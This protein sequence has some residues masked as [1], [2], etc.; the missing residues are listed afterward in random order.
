MKRILA[1]P[2]AVTEALRAAP[3]AIELVCLADSLRSLTTKGIEDLARRFRVDCEV[4]PKESLDALAGKLPHQGVIAIT[5]EYSYVDLHTLLE[6]AETHA[7]PQLVVLDQI[8]DP[9]NLGAIL[10]CAH[11]FGASGVILPKD[12]AAKITAAAVRTSAGA[13]ELIKVC[14]ITNLART[15]DE[16]KEAGY[17][18]YGADAGAT[19][20]LSAMGWSGRTALVMGSEGRGLR[21]LTAEHCDRLFK[22]PMVTAF[23]SLNV[24]AA[25]AISLY[26]ASKQ[27]SCHGKPD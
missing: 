6:L 23:D 21:R 4:M 17:R 27:R 22:I 3:G 18:I 8:Q 7:N 14:R 12:R 2:H 15:L 24:S 5:G 10:R 25:A 13:S 26:E 16:L 9:R 11:A 20:N 1:G 19:D